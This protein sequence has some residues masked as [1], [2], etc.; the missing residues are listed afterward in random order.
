MEYIFTDHAIEQ[1]IS[2]S[3]NIGMAPIKNPTKT[4]TKL[5]RMATEEAMPGTILTRRLISNQFV[6]VRYWVSQG[7]RFV[8]A[9]TENVVITVERVNPA[10]N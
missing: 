9:E 1:F 7:W 6:S 2:R 5:L 4:M 8:L 3:T 10:Q